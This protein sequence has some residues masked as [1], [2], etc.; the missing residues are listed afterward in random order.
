VKKRLLDLGCKEG[1]AGTGY[2]RAGFE[3]VGVDIEPQPRYPFEFHQAD[4]FDVLETLAAGGWPWP[5]DG[6]PWFD[7]VHVSPVCK[8]YSSATPA[9]TRDSHPDQ[10]PLVRPLLQATGV[11]WVMENVPRAP[12]RPDLIIC[13]CAVGLHELERERWFETNWATA[14]LRAPCYH[15]TSPITVAGH[16]E[17]SGP[18]MRR[19]EIARKADWER[20]MGIDWMTRDG[21]AQAIPPA[22]TEHIGRQLL[23][24]MAAAA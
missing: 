18:R 20:V 2:A 22:Y 19:G 10:I 12:L 3:V 4:A 9:R 1:G 23:A 15:A 8:R 17:P 21:L 24:A 5:D 14:E 6:P 16:G 11:P 7:A 13:G